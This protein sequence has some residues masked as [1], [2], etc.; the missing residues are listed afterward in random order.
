VFDATLCFQAVGISFGETRKVFWILWLKWLRGNVWRSQFPLLR[1]K[2]IE[3]YITLSAISIMMLRVLVLLKA[4]AR[5]LC[6]DVLLLRVLGG[7]LVGYF[8]RISVVSGSLQVFLSCFFAFYVFVSFC[9]LLVCSRAP[10]FFI[11]FL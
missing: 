3:N 8:G 5:G 6:Y 10:T 1:L 7:F 9:I 2:G 11:K 4:E